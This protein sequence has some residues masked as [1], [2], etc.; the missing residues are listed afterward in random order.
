MGGHGY[1]P[2][3]PNLLGTFILAGPGVRGPQSLASMRAIDVAPTLAR[4]LGWGWPGVIDGAPRDE[5][6]QPQRR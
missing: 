4:L 6:L 5:V 1:L 2:D 3:H